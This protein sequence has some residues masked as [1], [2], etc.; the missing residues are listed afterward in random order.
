MYWCLDLG[1]ETVVDADDSHFGVLGHQPTE[2]ILRI[3]IT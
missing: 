3:K 2:N 1:R